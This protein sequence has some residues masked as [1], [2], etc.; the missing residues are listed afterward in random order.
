MMLELET[1]ESLQPCL[2]SLTGID[3]GPGP[4]SQCR[5]G[6]FVDTGEAEAWSALVPVSMSMSGI[7]ATCWAR[8]KLFLRLMRECCFT[9]SSL[10][11]GGGGG[12]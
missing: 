4:K 7:D 5:K 12:D 10:G 1:S 9:W 11:G 2:H 3:A 6:S 8:A